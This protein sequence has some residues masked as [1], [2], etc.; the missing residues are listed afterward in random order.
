MSDALNFP[1]DL[2]T[3]QGCV[4]E[5]G[6]R[7]HLRLVPSPDDV[8]V[9]LEALAAEIGL[10]TAL[11]T[12]SHVAFK[13]GFLHDAAAIT[14]LAHSKGALVLW[15]LSHSAGVVPI[16]LDRWGVD[17]AIGCTYKYLHG[18]PGSPAFLYVRKD[19]QEEVLSPIWGWFGRRSPFAFDLRYEP[20]S[21]V[22]RFLV[23]TPPIL[24]L[25]PIDWALDLVREAGVQPMRQKS[26]ALTSY[27]IYLFDTVL[28]PLAF[29]LGSPRLPE[30]RGSHVS[31]RHADGYRVAR[32]L[33]EEMK[34][35]PDFRE[36]DSIRLGLSPLTTSFLDVWEAV[37][38]MRRVVEEKRYE[39]FPQ[40]RQA[41]T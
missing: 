39:R 6:G 33:I 19:L 10:E 27:A 16:E 18:G 17:F 40:E 38:R 26:V 5:L 29:S 2:Y 37:D 36:P 8:S 11:V 41:V 35:L 7:H 15:D 22:R 25:L 3:L 21:G 28:A 20:A 9:P 24:S 30:R 14:E 1:S 4:Q 12:L 23:G 13:S 34:V 31:V 32:A